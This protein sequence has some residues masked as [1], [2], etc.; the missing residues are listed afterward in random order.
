MVFAA[1]I[2]FSVFAKQLRVDFVPPR[3][4]VGQNTVEIENYRMNRLSH[5]FLLYNSRKFA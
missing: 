2:F 5:R 1:I 3:F 4:G